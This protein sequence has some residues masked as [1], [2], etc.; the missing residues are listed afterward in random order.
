MKFAPTF[1]RRLVVAMAGCLILTGGQPP[2]ARAE[3]IL[4]YFNTSWLEIAQKMPE[5]VEAG[6]SALWLPPPTKGSGGQSVGYDLWDSFDL[7]S[8]DQRG[9]V[10]TRYGTEAELHHLIETAHRFGVRVYFDIIHNHRAFDVPGY[11]AD[12]PV[13]IYPGMLPEDFHLKVTE[14]GFYRKWDN[15][16][17]WSDQ[18][19]VQH[20]GLADL[21]DI[22]HETPNA[23]FGPSEGSTHPKLSFVRDLERPWQYD[24]VPDSNE[25]NGR[26]YVGF[27]PGNGIT[28]EFVA[29]NPDF[30]KEDVGAY[31]IRAVRWFIDRT[32]AD[33]LRLDAV[34]HVASYFFGQQSGN[35]DGSDAGY[36]G[37]AQWQFNMTR[38]FSDWNNHRDSVFNHNQGR[39]DAMM[40]GEHLGAPP[41]FGE[42]I[43]AGMRLLDAPLHREMNNRLGN[44]GS[45]LGG[46]DSPGWSGDPNF[47]QFTGIP[48]A[49]S[50]DDDIANRRELQHAYYMTRSGIPNVYTDG[51]YEAATLG[52]SGG[53]FPRH[54]NNP[55]L[56]QFGDVRLPNLLGI[57]E[58]FARGDQIPRFSNGDVVVY[59]RR[60]KRENTN[61]SDA[62]GTVLLFMMN[63]NY[64]AGQG[65]S[66]TTSFPSQAGGPAGTD[67]YL[68]NYSSYGGGFYK[69][70][71]EIRSGAVIVPPGGYFAFSWK[72]PDPSP[73]WPGRDPDN[74]SQ[75]EPITIYQD[76]VQAGTVRVTRRDGPDGD[77]IFNPH[78][79]PNR[80]YPVGVTPEPFTY[81]V[82]LPRVTDARNLR[83]LLAADGS[84]E[85]VQ[86]KLDGGI[87]INSQM[88]VPF[89]PQTGDRRDNA[90]ALSTDTFLGYE[91]A[92][93]I[94]RQHREKFAAKDTTRCLIGS[95][96]AETFIR[97]SGGSFSVNPGPTAANDYSTDNLNYLFGGGRIASWIYHDPEA[98]VGGVTSPP[99]QFN[100]SGADIVIW[101]KSNSVGLGFRFF[102]YY[103]TDGT[104]PEGAG[105]V[106]IGTTKVAELSYRHNEGSDDWWGSVSIPEPAPGSEIRYKIG[107]FKDAEGGSPVA[108]VWP[109]SA[110]NV[111]R[112]LNM[113]T[114][115][116][117]AN[118]NGKT[119]SFRP[120]N[121]YGETQV[122]LPD[123]WHVLRGRAYLNRGS[124]SS[125]HAAI[126]KTFTQPFYLDTET[127]RGEVK[128]PGIN[129]ESVGGQEYG[130]VVR[131]DLTVTEV[132]YH[133]A[134]SNSNNDD[135]VTKVWGGNGNGGEPFTDSN[136]N[137]IRD[138]GEPFEDINVNG[139]FD[140]DIGESWAKA[141]RVT[142][143]PSVTSE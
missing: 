95:R 5:V 68:Y 70:A 41:P 107:A 50:H 58:A 73:F 104:W 13:D 20:L 84:T 128:F 103:T 71:S 60:D 25:P 31:L 10:R 132:W 79:L 8:K 143:N 134:D 48:F 92:R 28:R 69:Y 129:G 86:F 99:K 32:K 37:G 2:S 76:G 30:Y 89:G 93:F 141:T 53:N 114:L 125:R 27:G 40:F 87:D 75:N 116:E 139:S 35:K 14:E 15:T 136:R 18:W 7:G 65:A 117:V 3:V 138:T 91:Q 85:N 29:A 102:V 140:A 123:G 120:H 46:L 36:L 80:G 42:Y 59:E 121:D 118:F 54:A 78:N 45:G 122:G 82:Q 96:G 98:N 72:N 109:G 19:Q 24:H 127:P 88:G 61:M 64:A 16:R 101:A 52:E 135:G 106:G 133:I 17:S 137:G 108:S 94:R 67:A 130:F 113:L 55:F 142:A 6:Y 38:G 110:G 131:T 63:D 77:P 100:D 83:F 1:W 11:N 9:S 47:N 26:R 33:G 90:P 115:F 74:A 124:G 81:Q 23:N 66:F 57:N 97:S 112:K 56:G 62:D 21:I 12:T 105:G 119:V 4:Q 39:D 44:P 51:Y 111:S 34:K 126:Y 43:A 49:Q 22:A